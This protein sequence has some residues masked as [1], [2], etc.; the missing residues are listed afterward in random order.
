MA[1]VSEK[2]GQNPYT[3]R[4]TELDLIQRG[5][6]PLSSVRDMIGRQSTKAIHFLRAA[7]LELKPGAIWRK[8]GSIEV[9]AMETYPAVAL[10]M[11]DLSPPSRTPSGGI[12]QAK[13]DIGGGF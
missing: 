10:N 6:A 1:Q 3:R 13:A 5:L 2:D 9:S 12:A 11:P 7:N 4:Q 8:A